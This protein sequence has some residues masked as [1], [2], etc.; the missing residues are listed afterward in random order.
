MSQNL[1]RALRFTKEAVR[2][3]NG[4]VAAQNQKAADIGAGVLRAGGNAVD[5]AVATAFALGVLEP[6]MSGIGGGGFMQ[7]W[8]ARKK[9]GHVIDFGMISAAALDPAAYPLAEGTGGDLFGWPAVA[10]DR[11]ILG[12][13][14]IAVPGQPDGMRLALETFGT[15]SWQQSLGPAIE[16][17]QEGTEIDWF[18]SLVIASAAKDLARFPASRATFLPDGFAPSAD[19]AGT[20]ARL[21]NPALLATLQRLSAAGARDYYDGALAAKLVA[22]LSAGGS[23]IAAADL[24]GYQARLLAPLQYGYG[25]RTLLLPPGLTAGPTLRDALEIVQARLPRGAGSPGPASF[26]AYAEAL[27]EAYEKRLAGMGD[28]EN[29]GGC[30]THFC[31]IDRDGNMASVTQT[32]LSVFGS[33]VVLPETGVPMNN[34][35]M[36]FDPRPGRPNSIGAGKRPLSNMLPVLAL[37]D[38][39]P[40]L[41]IG[42]SGGRR[43]LPAVMQLLSFLV[44]YRMPLE[45][46]FLQPRIDASVPGQPVLDPQLDPAVRAAVTARFPKAVER[47]RVPFPLT[48]ACPSAVLIGAD[49]A[50]IGMAEMG[51]PWAGMAAA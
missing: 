13:P 44:D 38:G 23:K 35:I 4:V 16:L 39:A 42:A 30:T 48:Y 19:L 36:W 15:R 9:Q 11:N 40:W 46:A 24:A 25:D 18:L 28:T 29:Q 32:L 22:D 20:A 49:G 34:G 27:T 5:A 21:R 47:P 33:R 8:D 50:R 2:S 43:I 1:S 17:A 45:D 26:V 31:I 51:Q 41:A 12:Y 14:S 3:A 7:I 37:A 6:W 10:E